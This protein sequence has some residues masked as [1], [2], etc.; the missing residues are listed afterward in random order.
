MR[1]CSRLLAQLGADEN[2]WGKVEVTSL[3]TPFDLM[4][5]PAENSRLKKSQE[6]TFPVLLHALMLRNKSVHE[7]IVKVLLGQ[8]L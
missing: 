1:P 6:R 4:I 7:T 5:I 2:P 3:W 8:V